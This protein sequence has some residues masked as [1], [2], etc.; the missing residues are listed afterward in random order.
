MVPASKGNLL[1]TR[2]YYYYYY[3]Y[4]MGR[5]LEGNTKGLRTPITV[6]VSSRIINTRSSR[7]SRM[8]YPPYISDTLSAFYYMYCVEIIRR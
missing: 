6:E 1:N 2:Y 3:Y 8:Y 4:Y 5:Q 7:Y